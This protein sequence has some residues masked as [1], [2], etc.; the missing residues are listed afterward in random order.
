MCIRDRFNAFACLFVT[1][2]SLHPAIQAA[3]KRGTGLLQS[4]VVTLY[5]SYWMLSAV[6][7]EPE[8]G[9]T[10]CNPWDGTGD[11]IP[12]LLAGVAFTIAAVG[13]STF[14]TATQGNNLV[15]STTERSSLKTE[16]AGKSDVEDGEHDHNELERNIQESAEEHHG[17]ERDGVKY[18]YTFF[19]LTFVVAS[20]YISML[21]TN[22]KFLSDSGN[23]SSDYEV[24]YG[25]T[26]VWV[27]F[28][29]SWLVLLLYIWTLIAPAILKNRDFS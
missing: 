11:S 16:S 26:S 27:K 14:R 3:H 10:Q 2:L 12:V 8:L 13:F 20:M 29:S 21:V 23:D 18:N 5:C 25:V 7:S 4:G 1:G 15:Q 24:D 17:D 22:W 9:G 6:M 19:H 28:A